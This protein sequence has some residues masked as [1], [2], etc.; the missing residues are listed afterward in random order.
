[1]FLSLLIALPLVFA[2]IV[3]VLPES[4]T[5][6]TSV[7]LAVLQFLVSLNL[8]FVFDKSTAALQLVEKYPWIDTYGINYFVGIDGI[9]LWLVLMTALF[10]PIVILGSWHAI[11]SRVKMFHV[12][13]FLLQAFM[14]G[15]FLSIDTILFYIFFEAS[16][17]PMYL[18]IGIWGGTRRIY[19]TMKFFIYTMSGSLLMLAAII[20]MML[21]TKAQLGTMSASLLDFYK[22]Q[23]PFVANEFLNM[24]TLL[25]VAFA[26][27]FAIK[28]PMFPLHTWLPDAHVE[29]PTPGS[30]VLAAIM[31]KMG[32]YGFLRFVMPL[33]P[34]ATQYWGWVFMVLGVI[35][36]VYGALV[37][38]VQP[39]IK[40]LVAYSSVSHMGYVVLGLFAFNVYGVT[41]GLYQMLNHGVSTGAL[42]LLVG[43]IYER[44][45]S[46]EIK[47]YGGLASAMPI[48]TILFFIVTF[49]SIAVP[50][51]NGFVGEFY[52]LMGSFIRNKA[53][54]SI[55]VLGVIAGAT[56]MLWMCK[57]VFF[58]PKG[59]LV[60][61]KTE[62]SNNPVLSDVSLREVVVLA[63]LVVLIFWMGLFP[64]QFLS[65]SKTSIEFLIENK[66]DY[67]LQIF[68]Q[69]EA[70]DTAAKE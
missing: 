54:G 58:G 40:K 23:I 61:G 29:A 65:Y 16:L 60:K 3:G 13:L 51:T 2:L 7:F 55:A 26:F 10:L 37:A 20:A 48:Y 62:E 17:I 28:V 25:F 14:F 66:S 5:R 11:E 52:I 22:L 21:M 57:K 30:V 6:M 50:G 33:F 39:D 24:Q 1:M 38:M 32:T 27:A 69:E 4:K 18:M 9:S 56:Y 49:S 70:V 12:N 8:L 36:I 34:E 35:G 63:P 41:G 31:L 59:E 43:M 53:L 15:T 44:T 45:H 46:R 64:N 47:N 68:G 19:A 67:K 42:F